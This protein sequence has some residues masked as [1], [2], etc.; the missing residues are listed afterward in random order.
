MLDVRL[1]IVVPASFAWISRSL[2]VQVKR[3]DLCAEKV[4][5]ARC[6]D[7]AIEECMACLTNV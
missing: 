5:K 1:M 6:Q 4:L 7:T 3:N 2:G